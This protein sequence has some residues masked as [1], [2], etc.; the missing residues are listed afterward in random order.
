MVCQT[1]CA[2]AIA[3]FAAVWALV[4]HAGLSEQ[5]LRSHSWKIDTKQ[6]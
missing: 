2:V 4:N 5:F 6:I 3:T 1:F